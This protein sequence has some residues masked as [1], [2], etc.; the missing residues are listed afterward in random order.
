MKPYFQNARVTLYHGDC[1]GILPSFAPC[2]FDAIITD[3]PYGTTDCSWDEKINIPLFW[4]LVPMITKK[5][6]ASIIFSQLPFGCD[7]IN[8]NR[9][10]FRYEIVWK[11]T[12]ACGFL[13]A[14]KMPLRAH[15][16]ILVFYRMLPT[17]N[18]QKNDS[19]KKCQHKLFTGSV[20]DRTRDGCYGSHQ[21]RNTNGFEWFDTG[22]RFPTDVIS[23]SN[24][25]G[26]GI[27]GSREAVIHPTQKPVS[28][29]EYLIRTYTNEGE[30]IL[31][32]FAGSGTA[33][34]AAM[35]TGRKAV[36]IEREEKYCELAA[37]R[38][39]AESIGKAPA[40]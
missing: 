2:A 10:N 6:C 36:L 20:I 25:N 29:I 37:K 3:P 19:G 31:D 35:R 8:A 33:G 1:F 12:C 5:N 7:L 21:R 38:L 18:P 4:S 22:K 14:K 30:T 11:K 13:N 39:E 17:Y 27:N 28:I 26:G 23:F 40:K 34:V 9:V 24:W 32:P 16:N 15:E